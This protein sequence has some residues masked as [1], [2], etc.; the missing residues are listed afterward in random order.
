MP[1]C[2]HVTCLPLYLMC[3]V[4]VELYMTLDPLCDKATALRCAEQ[5]RK[6][7][8]LRA[9]QADLLLPGVP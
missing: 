5:L 4:Q 2:K 8:G 3:C 1:G 9:S 7:L 6:H